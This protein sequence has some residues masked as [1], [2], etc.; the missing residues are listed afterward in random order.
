MAFDVRTAFAHELFEQQA[1]HRPDAIA[2]AGEGQC[3]T[4]GELNGRANQLARHLRD[5]GV[6]PGMLVAIAVPRSLDMAVGILGILKV[7]GAWVPLDPAGPKDRLAFVLKDTAASLLLAHRSPVTALAEPQAKIVLLDEQA[8]AIGLHSAA[9]LDCPM[10]PTSLAYV[11]YTS[12]STGQPKGVL[13]SHANLAHYID[14]LREPLGVTADDVYLHTATMAFS[15]SVRQLIFPLAMGARVVIASPD[16]IQ[17]P[18]ALFALIRDEGVTVL[19]L[20]PSYWRRCID[21]LAGLE[22]AARGALLDHRVRLILSASEPLSPDLPRRWR[23]EFRHPARLV[24]MFGQTET[25][26]IVTVYPIPPTDQMARSTVPIGRPLARTRIHLLDVDRRAVPVGQIGEI[27]VEGPGV[28]CGYLNQPE[29]T[30]ERF[31][32]DLVGEPGQTGIYRTGDLGFALPDGTIVFTGRTDQQVKIRGQRVELTEIEALLHQHERVRQVAVTA[33]ERAPDETGIAAYVVLRPAQTVTVGDLRR[34]LADSLPDHALPTRFVFLDRLPSTPSGKVDRKALPAMDET[35]PRLASA[36]VAPINAMETELQ[37]MWERLFRIQPIGTRDNFFELGGDSLLAIR[38]C[39]ELGD[40]FGREVSPSELMRLPT[41]EDLARAAGGW[42]NASASSLVAVHAHGSRPPFFCV[43]GF[44]GYANLVRYLD[45]DQPFYGLAQHL[46]GRRIRHRRVE[47]IATHY[48]EEVQSVAPKGPYFLGGHSFGAV[49]AFEMAQQITAH[50]QEVALLVL[51]DP[52]SPRGGS[53]S[54]PGDRVRSTPNPPSSP[55]LGALRADIAARWNRLPGLSTRERLVAVREAL[56]RRT[57]RS[58]KAVACLAFNALTI[59]LPSDLR[60]FYVDEIVYGSIYPRARA[61]YCPHV[62]P[63]P[64]IM[65]EARS[66]SPDSH[67]GWRRL[68]ERLEIH[69]IAGDH[70][71]IL[72]EPDIEGWARP[73]A[74]HLRRAQVDVTADAAVGHRS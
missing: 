61:T 29:L 60:T 31:P 43:H 18:T 58:L 15:S 7:G 28:G 8:A 4:Y 35:R 51:I 65:Y 9:N 40:R 48:L 21:T 41:I 22:E 72:T 10:A 1:A 2:V 34:F 6:R 47:D 74:V 36:F 54:W 5:G 49:V 73:L 39:A 56:R 53:P 24:N 69:E 45:P 50:G 27:Y 42:A 59:S 23:K 57:R 62:Y 12:G 13:I 71:S 11:I 68:V 66:G 67:Q 46:N 33:Y 52:L 3:L 37:G 20:V 14:A 30:A 32:H 17:D 63:G 25:T 19:D 44:N 70:L 55:G 26:G 16:R 38:F 64:A